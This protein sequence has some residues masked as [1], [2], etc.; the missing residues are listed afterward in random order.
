MNVLEKLQV[1]TESAFEI[2]EK[3]NAPQKKAIIALAEVIEKIC[4]LKEKRA[5][6]ELEEK[7]ANYAL[8][9]RQGHNVNKLRLAEIIEDLIMLKSV[10]KVSK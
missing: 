9:L 8:L 6:V 3:S 2:A 10:N 4:F 7:A 5:E 1:L